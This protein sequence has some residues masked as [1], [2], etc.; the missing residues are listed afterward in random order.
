MTIASSSVFPECVFNHFCPG[1]V[2]GTWLG[3]MEPSAVYPL[4]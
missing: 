3:G 2:A 4:V 1:Y